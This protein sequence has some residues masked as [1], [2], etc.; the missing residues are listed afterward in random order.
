MNE[1]VVGDLTIA[2]ADRGQEQAEEIMFAIYHV[3]MLSFVSGRVWAFM[4][5][6]SR[7]LER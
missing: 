1:Y 2:F 4:M 7:V 6:L 3:W 5:R